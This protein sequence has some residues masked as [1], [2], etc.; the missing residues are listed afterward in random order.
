[1]M[2]DL[3]HLNLVNAVLPLLILLTL[4]VGLP[5]VFA[6]AT[7]SQRRLA[8]VIVGTGVAVLVAGG[9]IMLWLYAT[10]N[11]GS[12]EEVGPVLVRSAL[13][14]LFWGPVLAVVWLIRAQGVERRRGLLMGRDA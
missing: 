1:M 12:V 3:L 10:V 9:A 8:I 14:S 13:M 11:G 6:R 7:L 2:S 5:W 4:T